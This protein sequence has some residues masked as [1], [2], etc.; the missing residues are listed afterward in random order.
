MHVIF[1]TIWAEGP[2]HKERS[3]LFGCRRAQRMGAAFPPQKAAP[4]VTF[5]K[6]SH[7][8]FYTLVSPYQTVFARHPFVPVFTIA[9]F[10][11]SVNSSLVFFYRTVR[12]HKSSPL[13]QAIS[14]DPEDPVQDLSHP[15]AG[16]L[17]RCL[18]P[19]SLSAVFFPCPFLLSFSAVFFPCP[20]LLPF[21]A[22]FF[23]C[24]F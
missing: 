16:L 20:F 7:Y 14:P 13:F 17:I 5:E 12:S 3:L 24:L 21:S 9:L 19:L 6:P 10:Y 2:L 22:V 4:L 15:G 11:I 1:F 23:C 8:T 18:F